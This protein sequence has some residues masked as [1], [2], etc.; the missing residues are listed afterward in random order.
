MISG[1]TLLERLRELAAR[2]PF[3]LAVQPGATAADFDRW[4]V[5]VPA[6]AREL[7][8][9]LGGFA[10]P[11][12]EFTL[13]GHPRQAGDHGLPHPHWLVTDDGGGGVTWVD[14]EADG[15]WG[16]VLMQYRE[17]GLH[18][19][20]ESL[21]HWL[22]RLIGTAEELVEQTGFEEGVQPYADDFWDLLQLDGPELPLHPAAELRGSP[23]PVVAR[24]AARVPDGAL[25]ADL[26]GVLPGSRA[27]FD[28]ELGRYRLTRAVGDPVFAAVP[29]QD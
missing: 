1:D 25:I 13:T 10:V 5:P 4:P 26:R 24:L 2:V 15:R 19:E 27:R 12:V 17:G 6:E 11:P 14:I 16:Q 29:S 9:R 3:D 7:L 18:V 22:D 8:G 23:D 21:P 28:R 20:A